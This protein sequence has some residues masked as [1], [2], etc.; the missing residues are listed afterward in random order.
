M[1]FGKHI[2]PARGI[3]ILQNEKR[4]GKISVVLVL[5]IQ[6]FKEIPKIFALFYKTKMNVLKEVLREVLEVGR[7]EI[8][9]KSPWDRIQSVIL[10]LNGFCFEERESPVHLPWSESW[11]QWENF[12]CF[13][14]LNVCYSHD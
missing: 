11:L 10:P 9:Q 3:Q 14:G 5:R 13:N 8:I 2:G 12:R 7:V 6:V 4:G 1:V